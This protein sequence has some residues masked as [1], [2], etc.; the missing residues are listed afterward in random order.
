[1]ASIA[2]ERRR[3]DLRM[4][5]GWSA[6]VFLSLALL[7]VSLSISEAGEEAS[8]EHLVFVTVGAITA[9]LFLTKSRLPW[10]L[11]HLISLVYGIAW[12]TF[13]LSYQLPQT[14]TARDKLLELGYRIGAWF[15]RTVLGGEIGA[16]PLMFS[17]VMFI[18]F[19]IMTYL[20]LWFSFRAHSLWAALLPSGVTLLFNLNYGPDRLSLVLVPYLLF[21]MLFIVRFNLYSQETGWKR[22]TRRRS[23]PMDADEE[24]TMSWNLR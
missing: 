13:V 19:W 18:L 2:L 21:T 16:D 17:V 22:R 4:H 11:T 7:M 8:L 9:S 5:E 1:M 10:F 14:F 6:F 23:M 15:Q 20:A 24:E 3:L 12:N